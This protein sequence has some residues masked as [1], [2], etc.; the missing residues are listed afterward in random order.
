MRE[1][2]EKKT[3]RPLCDGF[4]HHFK[5]GVNPSIPR[6]YWFCRCGAMRDRFG[7]EIKRNDALR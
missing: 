4:H 1:L 2:L 7:A 6:A 3:E 5:H